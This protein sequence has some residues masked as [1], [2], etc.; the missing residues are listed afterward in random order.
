MTS[1]GKLHPPE[2][3]QA[4]LDELQKKVREELEFTLYTGLRATELKRVEVS[5]VEPSPT[6]SQTP[7]I[8]REYPPR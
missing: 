6:G 1:K 2:Y 7:A 5:W 8:L 3:V 4:V